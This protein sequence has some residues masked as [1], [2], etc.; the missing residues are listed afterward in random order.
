MFFKVIIGSVWSLVGTLE[1]HKKTKFIKLTGSRE[2]F[3]IC[4]MGHRG[5][6]RLKPE[7]WQGEAVMHKGETQ[8]LALGGPGFKF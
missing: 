5:R 8:V 1:K 2:G 3:T 4:H 6:A 7:A